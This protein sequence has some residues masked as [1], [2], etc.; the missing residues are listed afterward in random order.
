MLVV[1]DGRIIEDGTHEEL[2]TRDGYYAAL[3]RKWMER[4]Q[5]FEV[6]SEAPD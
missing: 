2:V 4:S 5:P 1:D 6:A 3:H